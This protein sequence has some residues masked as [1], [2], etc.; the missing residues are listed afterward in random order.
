MRIL[1]TG[2]H[3]FL[4]KH[5]CVAL[6]R[7]QHEVVEF[8]LDTLMPIEEAVQGVDFIVHLAGINRPQ[9]KKDFYAGNSEFTD[10]LIK[11]VKDTGKK[12]PILMSS[13]VQACLDNDYGRSK[14]LA[15]QSLFSSGLPV[16]VYRLTN[17]FGKWCKP[18]YNSVVATFC[19]NIARGKDIE[20]RDKDFVVNFHYVEDVMEEFIKVIE[21]ENNAGSTEILSLNKV[22]PCSLGHLADL[23]YYFKGEV[24]SERHLPLIHDEFELKL[25]K[26]FCDYL[27]DPNQSFN[28]AEDERGYFEE[29]YKS[30][31]WGQISDNMAYPGITKGG[32]YH[33]YKKEIFYTVIGESKIT[34]K[35]I[36]NGDIIVDEVSGDLPKLV[37]I[38]PT[39]VHE[40]TNV[41]NAASHTL[42]WVSEIYDEASPD[43]YR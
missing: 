29:I 14:L 34:Q 41:G 15:E 2:S 23:L 39:Y 18:N 6:H 17:V 30:K 27:S 5:M 31:K 7:R 8:D 32:H 35:S 13:S 9:D 1:V 40:I 4:G 12:T 19:F 28:Y 26:T 11:A 38:I 33:L 21:G 25:F 37:S 16:Y 20:I 10:K 3:G 43:T 42:M 22:F 24:E 36:D